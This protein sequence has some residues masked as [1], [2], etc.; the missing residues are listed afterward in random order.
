MAAGSSKGS[1]TSNVPDAAKLTPEQRK[2]AKEDLFRKLAAKRTTE[3][4]KRLDVL[5][6]CANRNTYSYTEEQVQRIFDALHAKLNALEAAFA[7]PEKS[8]DESFTL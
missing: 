3:V 1:S 5:G 6:N 4:L 8:K 2:Q 7:R